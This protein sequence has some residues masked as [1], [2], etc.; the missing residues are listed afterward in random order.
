MQAVLAES[1]PNLAYPAPQRH[2]SPVIA[3]AIQVRHRQAFAKKADT[4]PVQ[5]RFIS[6]NLELQFRLQDSGTSRGPAIH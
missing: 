4:R 3:I 6:T 5:H 2:H 1:G